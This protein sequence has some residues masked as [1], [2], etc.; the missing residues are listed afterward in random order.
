MTDGWSK[1]RNSTS[2]ADFSRS[3]KILKPVIK[4]D[5]KVVLSSWNKSVVGEGTTFRG[6]ILG[7]RNGRREPRSPGRGRDRTRTSVFLLAEYVGKD[8]LATLILAD[9]GERNGIG[10]V[11]IYWSQI[12][13]MPQAHT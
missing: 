7:V 2:C 4:A 1:N 3:W 10:S 8:R 9:E 6:W 12:R 13:D 11:L 5:A